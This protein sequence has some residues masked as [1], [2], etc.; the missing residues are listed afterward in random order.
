MENKEHARGVVRDFVV[1]M[2]GGINLGSNG[3]LKDVARILVTH[4]VQFLGQCNSV[5]LIHSSTVTNLGHFDDINQTIHRLQEDDKSTD[6]M[7]VTLSRN[8]TRLKCN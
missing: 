7:F 2:D 1:G 5:Y 3:L 8:S 6:T 4:A